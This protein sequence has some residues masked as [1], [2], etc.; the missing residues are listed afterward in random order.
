MGRPRVARAS[1]TGH[2]LGRRAAAWSVGHADH[3][4]GAVEAVDGIHRV[5]DQLG[6]GWVDVG[7]FADGCEGGAESGSGR[8]VEG[9]HR[10]SG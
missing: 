1:A 3:D 4:A 8:V 9:G 5:F 7:L 6:A 2:A 10:R